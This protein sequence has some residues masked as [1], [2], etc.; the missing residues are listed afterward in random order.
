[1][2]AGRITATRRYGQSC[3]GAALWIVRDGLHDPQ[4]ID[5]PD[6]AEAREVARARWARIDAERAER[7]AELARRHNEGIEDWPELVAVMWCV[8][9]KGGA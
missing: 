7:A 6:A 9:M 8:V 3:A 5:A 4:Y 1:M 2:S